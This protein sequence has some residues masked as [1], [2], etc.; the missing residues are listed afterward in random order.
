MLKITG[1]NIDRFLH[2]L[3]HAHVDLLE[4]KRPHYNEIWI[5]IEKGELDHVMEIKTIYDVSVIDYYGAIKIKKVTSKNKVLLGC[6]V[7]GLFLLYFLSNVMFQ[8]EIVHNDSSIRQMLKEELALQGVKPKTFKKSYNELQKIKKKVLEEHKN[9]LEWLEIEVVGTKYIVR[10]E[11]RKLNE[12]KEEIPIRN[13]VATKHAI[14]KHVEASQGEIVRELN[15][16]VNPGDIIISGDIKL[17]EE[18]KNKTGANGKVYGEVWYQTKVEL[19]YEYHEK[20]YTGKEKKVYTFKFLNHRFELFNFKPFKQIETTEEKIISHPLLPISFALEHQKEIVKKDVVYSEEEALNQAILLAKK[21]IE[22]NL[23][24]K[25][26]I[27]SQK[28]LKV[29]LRNSKIVVEVFFSVYE[30]ITG[31]SDIKEETE[32]QLEE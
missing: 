6:I 8:I 32:E 1:K 26:Y 5:K 12:K 25:E 20:T 17:N 3:A 11:E 14:I 28:N 13:I 24:K 19:P 16:Y 2:R 15:T 23:D 21:K 7:F 4:V 29:D 31:Y 30:D 27:I 18:S 22:R 10:V 9:E